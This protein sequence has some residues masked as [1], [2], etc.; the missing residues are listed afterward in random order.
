[1]RITGDLLAAILLGGALFT[2]TS[3]D[4][5][6]T[7]AT[8]AFAQSC[9]AAYPD[10]CIPPAPDVDCPDLL[11]RVNFTALAPDPHGLDAD[12]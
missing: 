6:T 1:M 5:V 7:P 12:K 10:F 11:P 4:A 3:T 8:A 2:A 9:S